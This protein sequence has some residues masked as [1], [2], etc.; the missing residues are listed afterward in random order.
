[1]QRG[2]TTFS[3]FLSEDQRRTTDPDAQLAGLL[4]NIQSACTSTVL[5]ISRGALDEAASLDAIAHEIINRECSGGGNLCAMIIKNANELHVLPRDRRGR[6]LLIV[7]P[8]DG[9]TNADVNVTVGT[10]FSV[11][12]ARDGLDDPAPH[13]FL[14]CGTHQV[15]A[16]FAVYGPISMIVLS[17]GDSVHGFTLDREA[18]AYVLSH[19]KMRI[20]E[21]TCE[22]AINGS[23]E[24][25]WEPPVRHYVE[26]CTK[27]R[28]GSRGVDF[29]MRWVDSL[30]AEVYRV[31]VRGGIFICPRET[32]DIGR[33]GTL[34]LLHEANPIAAIVEKAGGAASTGRE[35]VLDVVPSSIDQRTPLILGSRREVERLRRFHEMYD[36][37]EELA[38][39]TPLFNTRS[40]FRTS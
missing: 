19:P 22:F 33:Y 1:M 5:A 27:G 38:F 10:T 4:N 26:E 20:P 18:S 32:T 2:R 25:F 12:R 40:L 36:R 14:Q 35:R 16:G 34:S 17:L 7:N 13:D 6:Y 21:E 8:I 24:R 15:A 37:G 9:S 28:S 39:E 3:K 31:L 11:L 30:V 23:N 29:Q